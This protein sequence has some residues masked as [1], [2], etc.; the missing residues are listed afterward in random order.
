MDL[1]MSTMSQT[2]QWTQ[3]KKDYQ[4]MFECEQNGQSKFRL[5]VGNKGSYGNCVLLIL[6]YVS[7]HGF[8]NA[9]Y[10]KNNLLNTLK[11]YDI[12]NYVIVYAQPN[13]SSG[14]SR[15]LIKKSRPLM[16]KLIEI[17]NPKFIVTFDDSAAELFI[18]QKP[19]IVEQHGTEF[20]NHYD[21]PVILTYNMDYYVKR[22]GYEDN[23]YK[24]NI[25]FEDWKAISDKYKLLIKE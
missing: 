3:L 10:E 1:F 23:T 4:S 11:T 8:M 6:P 5:I 7:E 2:Q 13:K 24:T 12:N 22:T 25:F 16:H 17:V 14:A 15:P 9:D 21:I 18:N 19:N 20:A